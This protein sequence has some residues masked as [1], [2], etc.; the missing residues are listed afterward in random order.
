MQAITTIPKVILDKQESHL[1][2]FYIRSKNWACIRSL[3]NTYTKKFKKKY[4]PEVKVILTA[5]AI[6]V[7][8]NAK[9]VK[10]PLGNDHWSSGTNKA[11]IEGTNIPV[12]I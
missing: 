11:I 7:K 10:V 12:T 2:K 9:G 3:I 8:A 4:H 6:A 5:L 1:I